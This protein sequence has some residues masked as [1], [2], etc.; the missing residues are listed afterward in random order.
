MVKNV[1]EEREGEYGGVGRRWEGGARVSMVS[2]E[3]TLRICVTLLFE[4]KA[5]IFLDEFWVTDRY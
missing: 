5:H 1:E 3:E 4:G 2:S